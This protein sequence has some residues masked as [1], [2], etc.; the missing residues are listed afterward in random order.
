MTTPNIGL[1]L[2][3][4]GLVLVGIG[5]VVWLGGFGW[6]GHL[7]GDVR[8]HRNGFSLYVP[9]TSMLLVSAVLSLIVYVVRRFL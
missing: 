2:V 1:L 9:I 3:V 6:L 4:I 5:L 8:I 7:P